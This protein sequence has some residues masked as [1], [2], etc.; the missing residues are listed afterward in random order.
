MAALMSSPQIPARKSRDY[1][2]KMRT[3]FCEIRE[4]NT[5]TLKNYHFDAPSLSEAMTYLNF[6]CLGA[7]RFGGKLEVQSINAYKVKGRKYVRL[8]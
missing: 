1:S 4:G 3:C 2:I 8:A 7:E 6:F 5:D